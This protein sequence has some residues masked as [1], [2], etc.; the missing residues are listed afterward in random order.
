MRYVHTVLFS[1]YHFRK[2]RRRED[3][4]FLTGV[5]MKLDCKWCTSW[6]SKS[7]NAFFTFQRIIDS[8]K[9]KE[10]HDWFTTSRNAQLAVLF[11]LHTVLWFSM[12]MD[13]CP[14]FLRSNYSRNTRNLRKANICYHFD[15][16]QPLFSVCNQICPVHTLPLR[17]FNIQIN[18]ILQSSSV[19]LNLSNCFFHSV[20]PTK[21]L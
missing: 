17:L 6:R 20:H 19:R 21:I 10:G 7:I 4:A 16:N 9:S 11:L 1:S 18:N 3:P 2:Y 15:T 5:Q 8:L 13:C 12:F 14:S